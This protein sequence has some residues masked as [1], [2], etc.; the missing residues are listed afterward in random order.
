MPLAAYGA[1]RPL[2]DELRTLCG[3][4]ADSNNPIDVRVRILRPRTAATPYPY[5]IPLR[6]LSRSVG[7]LGYNWGRCRGRLDAAL[8]VLRMVGNWSRRRWAMGLRPTHVGYGYQDLLTAIR[9]VDVVLGRATTVVV[10]TKMFEGDRFDDLTSSW[11]TGGRERLQIKHTADERELTLESF[12]GDRRGLQLDKVV[13]SVIHDLRDHTDTSYRLVVRDAEPNDPALTRVLAPVAPNADPGPVAPG[14]SSTRMRFDAATLRAVDPWRSSLDHVEDEELRHVCEVLVVDVGMPACSLDIRSPGPAEQVLL[15]R[16]ADE[17]GAGRPPNR[18]RTPEDVALALIDA[19]K[20]ARSLI[21]TVTAPD[22]LPRLDLA[23]DFG[24]VHEGH[25]VD[26]TVEVTRPTVLDGVATAVDVSAER[27]AAVVLTGGPGV[28]KSWLCEQLATRLRRSWIVARHHCWLGSADT[29]R[30][31]RVLTEVVIGSLLRQLEAAAPEAVARVRPRFAATSEN[32]QQA[33]AEVRHSHPDRPIV[34]IVDGL[35]HVTRVVGRTDGAVFSRT[36]DPATILVEELATLDL[37]R[38]AVVLIASQPGDHLAPMKSA[39]TVTVPPLNRSEVLDLAQRLG[40]LTAVRGADNREAERAQAAVNLIH[41]RSR[42]NALYATYLCRQAVGP[43]ALDS[44]EPPQ[45]STT[46]PLERLR[47]VPASAQ[48]LDSYYAYLLAGLTA[49]QRFAVGLLA[50][51]DFAV[52]ADEL[53]EIFPD[54]APMLPAALSTVAPIVTQ[55][56]GIGGLKIHHESFSRFVRRDVGDERWLTTVRAAAAAWLARRG[57][58]TDA[59]AF[60]HLPELL[61]ELDRDDDLDALIGPDFLCRAIAGLQPPTAIGHVLNLA[62]RRSA[63][64]LDWPALVRLVELRGAADTY[65]ADGIP[66]TLVDYA[67]VLVALLGADAIAA[68]LVYDGLPTVPAR[69]GLQLCA[70]VDA[71][72]AAVPWDTYLTAWEDGRDRDN[73]QYGSDRDQ[74]LHLAVQRGRLRLPNRKVDEHETDDADGS[75]T[76]SAARRLATHLAQEGLPPM[77]R[78]L[79]VFIDGLGAAAVLEA[80]RLVTEPTL[81]AEALLHLA[82]ISA[83][84]HQDLPSPCTLATEAWHSSPGTDPVRMLRHGVSARDLVGAVLSSDIDATLHETTARVLRDSGVDRPDVV[85]EWLTQVTLAREVDPQSLTRLL[86]ELEGVGF[87]RAWLRFAVTTVGLGRDVDAGA[88]LPESASAAVRVALDRLAQSAQPF[89]GRPR[90]C[91]LWSIHSLVHQ[92]FREAVGLLAE[93]DLEPALAS[94]TSI[95][96]GTTTTTNLGTLPSGPL[97]TTDLL[98]MLSRTVG[99][100][101]GTVVHRLTEQL[102]RAE[103]EG[104]APYPQLAAFELEMTRISLNAGDREEALQCWQRA[105]HYM[106]CY[107]SHKDTTIYELLDPLPDLA[108]ADAE[109]ARVRLARVRRLTYLVR[110]HTNGRGTSQ[111]PVDWWRRLADLDA[112]AAARLAADVLLAEPGLEDAR[113]DAVHHQLLG[114]EAADADPIVLAALRIAAGPGGRDL[115][116]DVALLNRLAELS[117]DDPAHA[118]GV[119]PVVANAISATY[120]DQ[121]LMYT[122]RDD[123]PEPTAALRDAA[124]RLGGDGGPPRRPKPKPEPSPRWVGER[125]RSLDQVLHASQRPD[126]PIGAAGAIAAV[127]DRMSR[128]FDDEPDAPRWAEDALTSAIGWRLLQ[129]A[130]EDGADAAIGLLHRVVE[131][132][133]ALSETRVLADV[134]TGLDLRHDNTDDPLGRVASAAYALAFTNIRGGGWLTFAGRDRPDLWQRA[135]ALDA[136]TATGLL[137][138]GIVTAIE[139]RRYATHGIT[140]ALVAAFSA[141]SPDPADTRPGIAFACWDSA[142][143]VIE[144]RLPGTTPYDDESYEPTTTRTARSDTDD[145]LAHLALATIAMPSRDDRRRALV[146]ATVLIAARPAVGQAA[147]ARV[148]AADL[149]AGPLTW[150]LTVV[151]ECSGD[152]HLTDEIAGELTALSQ[153]DLLSVRTSAA[154]ILASSGRRVPSPPATAAHPAL[155]HGVADAL[156]KRPR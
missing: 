104:G 139:G 51:C 114:N 38:G 47:T 28:G 137:T 111:T 37:P 66:D 98:A 146:A 7:A 100:T 17:L 78:L 50:V 123:G 49:G 10:D 147:A 149:G 29:E 4:A 127:R 99:Q 122:S 151:R 14:M 23:V 134:A 154:E 12:T 72:G 142:F 124:E 67:D 96:G 8:R 34:L 13:A 81:R 33:V 25:P 106:A 56:P 20:A 101:A 74:D 138:G 130:T 26:P 44:Q 71:A 132:F 144:H 120:D 155:Q 19:A 110:K 36:S 113:V 6:G 73:V 70:A 60:R 40:V 136:D 91:D 82:D 22:L 76:E 62:A 24:A 116:R 97:I 141:R 135:V 126:L 58:F 150:L 16:V 95:S 9:L 128:R 143:Q 133:N 93:V 30:E 153:S 45:I 75:R 69:W 90:A 119:L 65:E 68:S 77:P 79:D 64:R 84:G 129:M 48:D 21:G 105:A 140:R 54:T 41:D 5:R 2:S 131:E 11:R 55:Q 108:G 125:Q 18:H 53:R 39:A 43:A 83:D 27:G 52:T 92:V 42:G 102:R 32:L 59:R 112:P 117:A 31:R 156:K 86:P 61:V 15:R 3:L 89:T 148:L 85:R 94:L 121:P 107:G 152:G 118:A 109:Q 88:I 1:D 145:A 80:A 63:A 57:F 46:D 103:V 35:D 115:G 87:Y